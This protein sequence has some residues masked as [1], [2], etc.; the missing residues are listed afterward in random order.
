MAFLPL[1]ENLCRVNLCPRDHFIQQELV[2]ILM[3]KLFFSHMPI[4]TCNLVNLIRKF[5]DLHFLN[6]ETSYHYDF[7]LEQRKIH[8]IQYNWF[9]ARNKKDIIKQQLSYI[10]CYSPK[11]I[12]QQGKLRN[13]LHH[14]LFHY[15]NKPISYIIK[16]HEYNNRFKSNRIKVLRQLSVCVC[17]PTN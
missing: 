15:K 13:S 17:K 10:F 1:L 9:I 4:F 16:K 12:N 6:H 3:Q 8:V 5:L 2:F 7:L 14:Q 11:S